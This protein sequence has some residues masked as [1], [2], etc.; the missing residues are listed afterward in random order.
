MTDAYNK[1]TN[2]EIDFDIV[3][4]ALIFT[5]PCGLSFVCLMSLMVNTLFKP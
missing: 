1:C 2:N 3:I 5:R 4:P